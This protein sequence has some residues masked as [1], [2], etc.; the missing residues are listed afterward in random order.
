MHAVCGSVNQILEVS[1]PEKCEY[2][3][4]MATP[5]ACTDELLREV[6]DELNLLQPQHQDDIKDE[7]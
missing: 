1:E 7:L 4:T 6:R 3:A 5:A 2:M